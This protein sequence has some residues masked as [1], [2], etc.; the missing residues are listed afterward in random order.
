MKGYCQWCGCEID[1]VEYMQFKGAH[2]TCSKVKLEVKIPKMRVR[3]GNEIF[4]YVCNTAEW[5]FYLNRF[6]PV[7]NL[8][9][10]TETL[11][12]N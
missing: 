3:K 12:H 6:Y 5:N 1:E 9:T 4:H 10:I 2:E 7:A 8:T 11:N